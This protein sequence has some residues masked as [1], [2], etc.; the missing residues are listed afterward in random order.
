MTITPD[1]KDWTWVLASACPECGLDTSALAASEVPALLRDVAAT[2]AEVL[3]DPDAARRRPAPA[4]WSA[5]EYAC[6]VRDVCRRFDA[7]LRL[8]LV[9]DD[10]AF[11]NWDQDAAAVQDGYDLQDPA[12][13]ALELAEAAGQ[14][15]D[16]VA[17]VPG[18]G[19][20]RPGRRSDGRAFTVATLSRYVAHDVVHHAHDVTTGRDRP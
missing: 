4:T 10:P 14:L 6:H 8:L 5:L 17:R 18:D 2:F 3:A 13:V 7:R 15:A 19:W 12:R 11:E 1:T 16:V 9:L 20:Q